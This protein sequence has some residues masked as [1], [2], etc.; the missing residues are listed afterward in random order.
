MD[1]DH[2]QRIRARAH[3]L[4]EQEGRPEGRSEEHWQRACQELAEE[5]ERP[6]TGGR[7]ADLVPEPEHVHE[8]ENPVRRRIRKKATDA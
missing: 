2:L 7:G 6:A 8:G 1:E 3:A 5:D 4:W